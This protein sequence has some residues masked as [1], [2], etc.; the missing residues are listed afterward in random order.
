MNTRRRAQLTLPKV[1]DGPLPGVL[2]IP[3]SEAADMDEYLSP[4]LAGVENGSRPFFQ[5]AEYLRKEVLPY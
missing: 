5:I 3:G 2:L 4:E 1:S